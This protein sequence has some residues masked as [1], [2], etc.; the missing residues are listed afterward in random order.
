MAVVCA[1]EEFYVIGNF[2]DSRAVESFEPAAT[3]IDACK[4]MHTGVCT[5]CIWLYS[6]LHRWL[7]TSWISMRRMQM[8][9]RGDTWLR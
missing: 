4:V 5:I 8:A 1:M 2:T 9:S 7:L 6:S 3:N